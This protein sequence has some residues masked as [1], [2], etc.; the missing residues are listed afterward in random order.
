MAE[1]SCLKMRHKKINSILAALMAFFVFVN[2]ATASFCRSIYS[3]AAGKLSS[4]SDVFP[5]TSLLRF[6]T[7]KLQN[8][9]EKSRLQGK[10]SERS[11]RKILTHFDLQSYDG[12]FINSLRKGPA[13]TYRQYLAE[14]DQLPSKMTQLIREMKQEGLLQT[15][16]TEQEIISEFFK[17]T[18]TTEVASSLAWQAAT[19]GLL[20]IHLKSQLGL[21]MLIP[22]DIPQL[23]LKNPKIEFILNISSKIYDRLILI[24][25]FWYVW[26]EHLCAQLS[27]E[28]MVNKLSERNDQMKDGLLLQF[29]EQISQYT[30]ILNQTEDPARKAML[31]KGIAQL[32]EQKNKLLDLQREQ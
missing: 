6:E 14:R 7:R 8:I 17:R 25:L 2:S 13:E 30:N 29:D 32:R 28:C 4:E 5:A 12:I 9:L 3:D 15:Q 10:I 19:L 31:E 20:V 22:V 18:N 23:R 27:N 1:F 21:Y 11:L 24:L 26:D 16:K